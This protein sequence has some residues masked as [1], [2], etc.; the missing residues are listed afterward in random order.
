MLT[1]RSIRINRSS[2]GFLSQMRMR[3]KA[4]VLTDADGNR[5]IPTFPECRAPE[6]GLQQRRHFIPCSKNQSVF[7]RIHHNFQGS[8]ARA[9]GLPETNAS[10]PR[11]DEEWTAGLMN[12]T[13]RVLRRMKSIATD[14]LGEAVQHA[15]LAVPA[16]FN[17]AE[18][19]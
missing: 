4:V 19:V 14:S 8:L 11:L 3:D 12:T 15:V 2:R 17:E 1:Q 6:I 10:L 5:N 13:A 18:R 7:G 9:H 16:Y